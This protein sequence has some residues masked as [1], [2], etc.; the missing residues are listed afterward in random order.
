MRGYYEQLHVKKLDKLE[1]MDKFLE[2]HNKPRLD[3]EEIESPSS[4]IMSK[5]IESIIKINFPKRIIQ[6]PN[7]FTN[8]FSQ[9]F[10]ELTEILLKHFQMLERGKCFQC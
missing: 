5:E 7:G 1:E 9:T 6:G 10:K 3:H 2:T 4:P 8:E